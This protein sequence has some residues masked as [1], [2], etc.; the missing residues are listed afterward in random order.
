MGNTIAATN[1]ALACASKSVP[2]MTLYGLI[3]Q[4]LATALGIPVAAVPAA[5]VVKRMNPF[6]NPTTG[7]PPAI[8]NPW[9]RHA[10]T[11]A[12]GYAVVSLS[13]TELVCDFN[14]IAPLSAGVAPTTPIASVKRVR[15]PVG[16]AQV[17]LG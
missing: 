13:K 16:K 15:V 9:I 4:N 7:V 8:N 5:E 12:Q 11:N 2:A 6:A 1:A 17:T 10:D 14:K 3:A